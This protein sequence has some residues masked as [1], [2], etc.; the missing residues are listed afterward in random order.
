MSN[1][2]LKEAPH[3]HDSHGFGP[4]RD[5][6]AHPDIAR[7]GAP[8]NIH[9]VKVHGGMVRVTKSGALAL[10]GNH[11][12]A[13]DA[14]SGATV[15]PGAVKS[16]P[17]Y[18]NSGVQSGHPFAKAPGEKRLTPVAPS[19]GMKHRGTGKVPNLEELGRAVLAQA[20]KN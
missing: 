2:F 3:N 11:A 6:H 15:V 19:F 17:G 4:V 1:K 13:L 9:S 20:I 5:G 12:S 16:T 7:D 14:V 18:G 8:K 10:G